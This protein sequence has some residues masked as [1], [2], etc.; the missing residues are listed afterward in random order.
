MEHGASVEIISFM[1]DRQPPVW[2]FR[3]LQWFCPPH[4][5]EE[6]EGDLLERFRSDS[7]KHGLKRAKWRLIRTVI[8][9]FR[10]GILLRNKFSFQPNP[11]RMWANYFKVSTR[12]ILRNKTFSAINISGLVLGMTG[13]LLLFLWIL[14]ESSYDQFHTDKDQIYVAWNRATENGQ[15]NCWQ[16]TPRV[17]APTLEKDFASVDKAASY[18]NWNPTHLFSAGGKKLVKTTGVFTDANFF[19]ILSFPLIKGDTSTVFD[20]P[21]SIVL[22][23]EFAADLFGDREALGE[24]LSIE[25]SGYTFDFAVTGILK[26]LPHNTDF[27]FDYLLPFTFLES[28][29]EKNDFWGNN[30]VTN[31]VKV[32]A[33]TNIATLNEQIKDLVKKNHAAGQHIEIFL[34][35]L[36]KMRLYSG[37]ENGVPSGGRIEIMRLLGLLGIFLI[38]IACIN[39]IN[40]YTARAQR[41]SREIAIRKVTGA[42]RIS[43]IA[44][45]LFEATLISFCAG[46]ISV[47]LCYLLIPPFSQLIGE[48]IQLDPTNFQLWLLAATVILA[49]GLLSGSYPALYLSSFQ[50]IR[51]LKGMGLGISGKPSLRSALVVFQFG[52]ALTL[53]VSALV[54][55]KQIMFVQN[56]E[57]GYSTSHL[58]HLPISDDLSKNY[59]AFSQEL[60][61][62]GTA[63][64]LTKASAPITEQWSGTTEMKW[65]GKNPQEKTDMQR[66]YVDQGMVTTAGLV[67]VQGRDMDLEKYPSDSTAVL[68]NETT[69]AVMGFDNPIGEVIE[70]AGRE[71]HVVGVVKD[72]VFTSP[73]QRIEPILLFGSQWKNALNVVY[74]KLN[75]ENNVRHN[76][77]T[78]AKIARKYN[79]DYPFQYHFADLE[80]QRKFD[81]INSTLRLTTLFTGVAIFIACLGLFGLAIFTSESRRKEIGIRKVMGGSVLSI[82]Q[83]LSYSTL[84]PIFISILLF[85]PLSWFSI[86]WWLESFAY[87][88]S[89]DA[90]IF[91]V[92]AMSLLSIALITISTQTIRAA[93]VNPVKSLRSE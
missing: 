86:N 37:F 57:P 66:I 90:S 25:Q 74:I 82:T 28:I 61:Q 71:W 59:H 64:S 43:L 70:D 41:R 81:G 49:V 21:A 62:S 16:I 5:L 77:E 32:K 12:V 4:L 10:P 26:N 13:A 58:I 76:L 55:R 84:K 17:L 35:P 51:I 18:A 31:L 30:S 88:T 72:F 40:L 23:E 29:G 1:N 9:F 42:V 47:A 14:H 11:F 93:R 83:L 63:V 75:S 38:A 78:L 67:I 39:F 24:T 34:Y 91:V 45:F 69:L 50:P 22:T 8:L 33:G 52:F 48:N 46:V 54:I 68:I 3:F 44:Q 56:R 60:L 80:Y 89:L 65:R 27:R 92:S 85:T 53:I 2:I 6:I 87:R 73:F 36:T 7:K 20:N 15:V 19:D 79:P